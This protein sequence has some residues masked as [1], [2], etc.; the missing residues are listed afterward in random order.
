MT[1]SFSPSDLASYP[2]QAG[3]YLMKDA[4]DRVLYVGKA[5]N[6]RYRLRQYF[7]SKGDERAMVPLLREEL[8]TIDVV[9]VSTEKEA[10][11]LEN[12]LIKKYKPKYNILL[13]DDKSFIYLALTKH[14]YPMLKLLRSKKKPTKVKYLFGPYTHAKAAREIF[15]F[16]LKLFPLRQCSDAEL[17]RRVRPCLLYDI[18]K[19][20]A[21]CVQKC[22]EEQYQF[23]VDSAKNLLQGKDERV[24]QDLERKMEQASENLEFELAKKYWQMFRHI[25]DS[26]TK[27]R[28]ELP[29]SLNREVIG[30]YRQADSVCL[31]VLSFREGKLL[32]SEPFSFHQILSEEEEILQTF[33]LQRYS[34]TSEIPQEILLPLK[35]A[36]LSVFEELLQEATG[37]KTSLQVPKMGEKKHLI[38]MAQENAKAL[39]LRQKEHK[40]SQEKILLELQEVLKLSRYP[41]RIECLD[42]SH[43]S[44]QDPVAALVCFIDG[45]KDSSKQRYFRMKASSSEDYASMKEALFRYFSHQ[46]EEK[47]FCDLLLVD[48][49]KGQL[50]I[51]LQVFKE[52]NIANIDV[53]GLAKEESLHTKALTQEKIFLPY[54]KAPIQLP[55]H[56]PLLFFLQKIRD[57]AHRVAITY[58]QKRRKTR[59][60]SSALDKVPG[61]GPKKKKRLLQVFGS[62]QKIEQATLAQLKEC[63]FLSSKDIANLKKHL[64]SI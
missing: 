44:L 26:L 8:T 16:I 7:S 54:Q 18:H 62:I 15:Q 30:F 29:D 21:P 45:K 34:H 27:Q 50:H 39:F 28:V 2:T 55:R 25:Q 4:S 58:H 38:Q 20:V 24:L 40:L 59:T 3:V 60:F 1:S 33:L 17:A 11:L 32:S 53:I 61:I 56:S 31:T 47:K 37:K 64:K 41:R 51:A 10:L 46:K 12:N 6:L 14:K 35:I 23:L 48:G 22:T 19:C 63:S 5:K 13:K 52:L 57:E 9:L 43:F 36:D 49:G 42:T